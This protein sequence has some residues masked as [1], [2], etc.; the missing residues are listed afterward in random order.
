MEEEST[1]QPEIVK[2][3]KL[4]PAKEKS[5]IA[6][7][8][9]VR[10]WKEYLGESLLIVFSVLFALLLTEIFNNIHDKQHTREILNAVRIELIDNLRKEQEQYL[11]HLDVLK[12]IDSALVNPGLQHQFINN[13]ILKLEAI[14]PD[15]VTYRD[16]NDVAWQVAKQDNIFSKID[17]IDYSLLT[18]IYDNQQRIAKVEQEI[19][20]L[21]LSRESRTAADNRITLLLMRDNFHAWAVDR[22]PGL[23]INYKKAINALEKYKP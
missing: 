3:E 6:E 9:T 22:A 14:V 5:K 23:L 18:D 20:T 2:S 21:L 10:T 4:P 7:V 17:L 1:K 13:G 19:G 8:I 11:Y 15:G 12:N 16:L